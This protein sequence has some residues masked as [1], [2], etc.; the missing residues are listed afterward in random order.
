[1]WFGEVAQAPA[2]NGLVMKPPTLLHTTSLAPVLANSDHGTGKIRVAG[3]IHKDGHLDSLR[4]L[5]GAAVDRELAA[6]LEGWQFT[7]ATRNGE[8]IDADA[9]IEI[10][11]VFGTLS[12][13]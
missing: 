8:P 5:A 7:P 3:L 13:R 9:V 10:P 2:T 12:L 6:G 1:V 4:E 11:V